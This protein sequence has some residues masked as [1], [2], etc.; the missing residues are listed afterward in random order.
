MAVANR[1]HV[2]TQLALTLLL[3]AANL[4][5]LNTLLSKSPLFRVDLTEDKEYSLT[6]VTR[7]LVE[8]LDEDLTIYGY[9]T[10]RTHPKL[11][12]LVPAIR[13]MIE[14]YAV[15]SG[16][17]IKVVFGDPRTDESIET[18]AKQRFGV[19]PIPFSVSGKYEN[20]ILNTY[21]HIVVA[22]GD[23]YVRYSVFD[24][25][26]VTPD[27]DGMDVTV[28]LENLE[29]DL[30]KAIKKVLYGF[31][32]IDAV[33]A[34]M[35]DDVE[36]VAWI[37]KDEELP[38]NAREIPELLEKV[39]SDMS[40][41]SN[42]RF[43]YQMAEPP[44]DRG[45]Q[46]QLYMKY[47][48]RPFSQGFFDSRVFYCSAILKIGDSVQPLYLMEETT[49]EASIR[50][51]IE[52]N[53]RRLV[54]GFSKTIGIYRPGPQIPPELAMQMGR[55]PE[56]PDF[57]NLKRAIETDYAVEEVKLDGAVPSN[58]DVLFVLRPKDLSDEQV[59]ELDQY[60]MRG[61][62]VVLALDR[63]MLDREKST[64]TAYELTSNENVALGKWLTHLGIEAGTEL[65]KDDRNTPHIIP[66]V[67]RS[68]IIEFVDPI[69][70]PYPWF[71]LSTS[72][73][74]ADHPTVNR[75][76]GIAFYWATPLTIDAERTREMEV[77]PLIMSSEKSWTDPNMNVNAPPGIKQGAEWYTVP[78]ET[79]SYPLAVS[80]V[81]SFRSYYEDHAPPGEEEP[82]SNAGDDGDEASEGG[83]ATKGDGA[84]AVAKRNFI[85]ASPETRL[86]V[87]GDAELFSDIMPQLR[88][89]EEFQAATQ[90]AVNLVDWCVEDSD[91]I[92]I[93]SRGATSRPLE[94]DGVS[95]G[96][97]EAINY[98]VPA[99]AVVL[100][101]LA[102]I[103]RR[104]NRRPMTLVASD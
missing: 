6:S 47:G 91:M 51:S 93:R 100:L 95:K 53:L 3:I 17:R 41:A 27:P 48:V 61:G 55:Q 81:G 94:L 56:R 30:T 99:V 33:F 43:R 50:E 5:A 62:R 23:Q 18:E 77:T 11:A 8:E 49:S 66:V 15:L 40:E 22:Y 57:E 78:E 86:V 88:P 71:P 31:Q 63:F 1:S 98:A 37:S 52:A 59:Y 24:L 44:Q 92:Q 25:I 103:A 7:N 67:R 45:A 13:D 76:E 34:D 84:D 64:R 38:E 97:I 69:Y 35:E 102:Q 20:S 21:F 19:E 4:V 75:L 73:A 54:P 12:P 28:R 104:R 9:F 90:F 70:V 87:L 72:D 58:I 36:V 39:C 26:E 42:G 46:E 74:M 10:Q 16:D 79:T 29:Y 83:D 96:V 14:E 82:A 80:M 89:P 65:L 101:G 60:L 85:T 32:S 2:Y 68:G